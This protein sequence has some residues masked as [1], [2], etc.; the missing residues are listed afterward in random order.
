VASLKA[1]GM[2]DAFN[3]AVANLSGISDAAK[4]VISEVMHK[5]YIKVDEQGTE[6]AA[7]TGIT[8]VATA[9]GPDYS[10]RVDR[11]FVFAIREKDTN[12]ILFV[13]KVMDPMQQ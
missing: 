3:D 2:T 8:I 13:G 5:T 7:V 6:A 10:F 12:T 11:P 9:I 4:L 1:L